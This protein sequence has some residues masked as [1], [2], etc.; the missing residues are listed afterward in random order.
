MKS[1]FAG[2]CNAMASIMLIIALLILS[3]EMFAL[4]PGFFQNEY[5][6]LGTAQSLGLSEQDLQ[7]ITKNLIDYTAGAR[8]NLDMQAS[9]NGVRREVFTDE[10]ENEHMIDVRA[11]YLNARGVRTV[12]LAGAAAL[13]VI[14]FI[15]S[16]KEA[17]KRLCRSFLRVSG[18]FLIVVAA[19][20]IYAAID[21]TGFW[22]SFHHVFFSNNLWQLDPNT[23]VLIRLV[24]EQ[25]FSD[26][27]T[28]IIIRFVSIFA[29]L[30]IAAG[31]GLY[32]IRRKRTK[33]GCLR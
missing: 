33:E 14:A 26:L 6:K 1:F 15:M 32:L 23:S 18:A 11:L 29:A 21:F 27:V 31:A 12:C 8:E 25:F 16:G 7:T 13:I 9:F 5:A 22:I 24:P 28:R 17:L 2:L 3:I 4:N 20:G 10:T 30:N 19:I